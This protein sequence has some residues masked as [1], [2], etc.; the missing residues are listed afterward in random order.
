MHHFHHFQPKR[1][2]LKKDLK[3]SAKHKIV[4]SK[5]KKHRLLPLQ[6][7]PIAKKKITSKEKKG[8]T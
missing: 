4:D 5:K 6:K 1:H 3:P 7:K 8:T 2:K